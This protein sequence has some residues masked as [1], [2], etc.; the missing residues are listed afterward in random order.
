METSMNII[1][2]D[3]KKFSYNG[4]DTALENISLRVKKGEFILLTGLSGCGKTTLIRIINGL[5]PSFY[6]GTLDGR[7]KFKGKNI[8][9]YEKG[10]LAKYMGNV[11]QDPKEQ[12]FSTQV[13][14]EIALIGENLGMDRGKLLERVD[15]VMEKLNLKSI[16]DRSVFEI[17][18]GQ[19]QRV[20]LASCL[21]YDTDLIV[22]DEPSASLDYKSTISLKKILMELKNMGKTIIVA[23]HRLF[24]LMDMVDRLVYMEDKKIKG[25]YTKEMFNSSLREQLNLRCFDE[26]S[27][28]AKGEK[29]EGPVVTE[30]RNVDV[31][32]GKRKLTENV[33]FQLLKGE[34]M[35][36]IGDNGIGKTTI[37]K[38]FTGLLK[39]N[40]Y[41]SWGNSLRKRSKNA[42]YV[43][44]DVSSQIFYDTVENEV[45]GISDYDDHLENVKY[46]LKNSDLWTKRLDSPQELSSGEK[47][48][49]AVI[50][51]LSYERDLVILDEPTAGLDY[52]RMHQIA[53]IIKRA[54]SKNPFIIVTHDSELIF[55]CATSAL[56]MGKDGYEKLDVYGNEEYILDFMKKDLITQ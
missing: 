24:Y 8:S 19:K 34:V 20:A 53:D 11:F 21:V 52:K 18:G 49:L 37:S 56:L 14:D 32:I 54:A 40:G 51:A 16:C 6:E 15:K 30:V 13:E 4:V 17:S 23:E 9:D 26:E 36:I 27:L 39:T 47:Q 48:R 29:I 50:T 55:S 45:I 35:A 5:I 2:V 25:I 10:E 43:M 28:V 41:T 12:F 38:Q 33:S 44:Q 46:L 31:K 3:L 42:Y 1:E 22:L 7:V